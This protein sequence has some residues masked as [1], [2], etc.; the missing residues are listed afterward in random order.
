MIFWIC[1]FCSA[2]IAVALIHVA[3]R[4]RVM[5][6]G[7]AIAEKLQERRELDEENRK[8]RL[9][10]SLLRNPERIERIARD[11]LGMVRADVAKIRTA[12]VPS[13]ELATNR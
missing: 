5:R 6:T 12:R 8:L 1:A 10:Q 9:E 2:A 7:Y 4:Y 3:L 13:G 11:K